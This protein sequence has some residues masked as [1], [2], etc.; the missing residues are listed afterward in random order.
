MITEENIIEYVMDMEKIMT[1][2]LKVVLP[3]VLMGFCYWQVLLNIVSMN[4]NV[5]TIPIIGISVLSLS[6]LLGNLLVWRCVI[7]DIKMERMKERNKS[8]DK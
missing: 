2:L 1:V 5:G 6:Y 4:A 8:K 7:E 3:F